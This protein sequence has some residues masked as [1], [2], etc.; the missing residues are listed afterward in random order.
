MMMTLEKRCIYLLE[1]VVIYPIYLLLRILPMPI[2]SSSM[3]WLFEVIGMSLCKKRCGI[4]I[5]NIKLCF[6][7]LNDMEVQNILREAWN[8]FGRVIGEGPYWQSISREEIF[9]SIEVLNEDKNIYKNAII[10]SC[11][12]GNW[13]L[14]LRVLRETLNTVSKELNSIYRQLNNPYL[15]KLLAAL[16]NRNGIKLIKKKDISKAIVNVL[17]NSENIAILADQ[18]LRSGEAVQF[19]GQTVKMSTLPAKLA[20]RYKIPIIMAVC[21]RGKDG[22][23]VYKSHQPITVSDKD[24]EITI[25]SKINSYFEDW[26]RKNPGQ[27][28]WFHKRFE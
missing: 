2:C 10:I 9:K 7:D 13:E 5:S 20:L 14:G 26:I 22:K 28:F 23:Y 11:H 17:K 18:K 6:P 15:N 16:R 4:A 25:M 19:F 3:G 21:V 27:W 24:N 1:T 12:I 8:N